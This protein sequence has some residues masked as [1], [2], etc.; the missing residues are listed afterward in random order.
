M[1]PDGDFPKVLNLGDSIMLPS[2]HSKL[3][4]RYLFFFISL[5]LSQAEKIGQLK[6]KSLG[7]VR[8][9]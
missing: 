4:E 1:A 5:H 6:K 3:L 9:V 2:Q 8:Q 7:K